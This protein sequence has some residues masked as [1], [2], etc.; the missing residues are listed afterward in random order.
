MK[1]IEQIKKQLNS[2]DW[3][4]RVAAMQEC[5]DRTDI[6]FELIERGLDDDDVCVRHAALRACE[7]RKDIP[8]EA[9]K[10]CAN[11]EQMLQLKRWFVK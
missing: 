8:L 10:R 6:P 1:T 3:L 7:C 5:V 2:D 4:I 11:D 9:I